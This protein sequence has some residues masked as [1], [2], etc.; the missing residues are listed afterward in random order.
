MP[1]SP[2]I[3]RAFA[4]VERGGGPITHEN[5]YYGPYNKLLNTLFPLDNDFIVSPNYL[6]VDMEGAADFIVTFEVTLHQYPVLVIEIKPPQ[7]LSFCSTREKADRQIR[8]RLVDLWKV[9]HT[10]LP[11]L[12]GISAVGTRLCFYEFEKASR[13]TTPRFIPSDPEFATDVA[14]QERWDCDVLEAD[15]E[16]RLRAL[17]THIIEACERLQA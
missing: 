3:T 7:H 13:R 8:N 16:Q 17:A 4:A 15:G 5:Q 6:P 9:W 14:P 10:P 12:Y 2:E 11:I 1:L